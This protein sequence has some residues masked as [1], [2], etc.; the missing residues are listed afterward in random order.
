MLPINFIPLGDSPQQIRNEGSSVPSLSQSK[1]LERAIINY[2]NQINALEELRKSGKKFS[3]TSLFLMEQSIEIAR[4]E[5]QAARNSTQ[6]KKTLSTN[7]HPFP[8]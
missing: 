1:S 6:A 3:S 8:Q 5:L 7:T 2:I 4:K